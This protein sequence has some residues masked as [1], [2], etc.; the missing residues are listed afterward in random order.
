MHS[1]QKNRKLKGFTLIEV[2]VVIA[3]IGI[4]TSLVITVYR[5]VAQDSRDVIARQQQA[6]IQNAINN[7]ITTQSTSLP[8]SAIQT[9]Y[10]DAGGSSERLRLIENYLDDRTRKHLKDL[11][12]TGTDEVN[13]EALTKLDRHLLLSSWG[14]NSYPQV[15]MINNAGN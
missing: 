1:R 6:A 11:S 12:P 2:I 4:M 9:V 14:A 10:N 15:Q 3:I 13:S 7:W 5:N 8:L